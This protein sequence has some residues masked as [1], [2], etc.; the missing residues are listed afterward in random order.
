MEGVRYVDTI[1]KNMSKLTNVLGDVGK[2]E[3]KG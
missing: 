3:H 2:L 1:S